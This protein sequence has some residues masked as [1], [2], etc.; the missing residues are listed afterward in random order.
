MTVLKVLIKGV[1]RAFYYENAGVFIIGFLLAFG[2][3]SGTEH[4]AIAAAIGSN[5]LLCLTAIFLWLL[6]ILKT[7][8]FVFDKFNSPAYR[9]LW[10]LSLLPIN[11]KGTYLIAVQAFM[12]LPITLYALLVLKFSVD[13]ENKLTLFTLI[14]FLFASHIAPV[15]LYVI[16]LSK[17]HSVQSAKWGNL[18]SNIFSYLRK[19]EWAWPIIGSLKS[20]PAL[21]FV[22]K[23][24]GILI[25]LVFSSIDAIENY[26]LKWISIGALI[27]FSTNFPI[28]F[29]IHSFK[30]QFL[31]IFKN[32]P[33]PRF[34]ILIK[35]GVMIFALLLPEVLVL[36]KT[37]A[38]HHSDIELV[39]LIAFGGLLN[40]LCYL[41]LYLFDL[42]LEDFLKKYFP[43]FIILFMVILTGIPLGAI[44]LLF[45]ALISFAYVNYYRLILH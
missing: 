4:K 26:N 44:T 14:L 29:E 15:I 42:N 8:L 1:G 20:R 41:G 22:S 33:S 45:T 16:R 25:L 37:F 9:F 5:N 6:Y 19:P 11:L 31:S 28:L 36:I 43:I 27:V 18:T 21:W 12:N 13:A 24:V 7:S 34:N 30:E 40:W 32:L 38:V 2:F 10:N 17:Y 3:L 39:S 23:P 35:E